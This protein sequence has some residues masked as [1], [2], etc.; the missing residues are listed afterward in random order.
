VLIR[1]FR[2][3][4][5]TAHRCNAVRDQIGDNPLG[6]AAIAYDQ[7]DLLSEFGLYCDAM[8]AQIETHEVEK[9]SDNIVDV[10]GRRD[11]RKL[12]DEITNAA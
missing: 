7:F 5:C 8:T 6:W 10:E 1:S 9:V 4:P 3:R 11:G 12:P 2:W